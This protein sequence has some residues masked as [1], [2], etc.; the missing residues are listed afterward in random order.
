M[1]VV[2]T[3][4]CCL[5]KNQQRNKLLCDLANITVSLQGYPK[6]IVIEEKKRKECAEPLQR[7]IRLEEITQ[8][9]LGGKHTATLRPLSTYASC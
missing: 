8:V 3:I 9:S 4:K 2:R 6:D 5:R 7:N 1:K